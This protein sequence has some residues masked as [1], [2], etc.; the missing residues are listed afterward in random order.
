MNIDDYRE[1]SRHFSDLSSRLETEDKRCDKAREFV[2]Y[3]N[4]NC[5]EIEQYAGV[6][7]D[8]DCFCVLGDI[9]DQKK[10]MRIVK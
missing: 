9:F 5:F 1:L 10:S 3:V 8:L 7:S 6:A 4:S 2:E